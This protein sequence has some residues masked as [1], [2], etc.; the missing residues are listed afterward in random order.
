MR[1]SQRRAD[2]EVKMMKEHSRNNGMDEGPHVDDDV[3]EDVEQ[4]QDTGVEES[5]KH[6][7]G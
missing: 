5:G 1:R 2:E 6:R 7:E 3:A 4:A